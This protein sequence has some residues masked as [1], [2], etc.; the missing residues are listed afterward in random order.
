[1]RGCRIQDRTAFRVGAAL[2]QQSAR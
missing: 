1:V 2:L